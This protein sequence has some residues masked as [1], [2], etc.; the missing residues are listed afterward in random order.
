MASLFM[1]KEGRY[2]GIAIDILN[3][4]VSQNGDSI[5][6]VAL[7]NLRAR[8]AFKRGDRDLGYRP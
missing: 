4:I 5:E 7:P 2:S 8:K 3:D 1:V 6:M